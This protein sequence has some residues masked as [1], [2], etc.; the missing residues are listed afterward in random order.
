[1]HVHAHAASRYAFVAT[2]GVEGGSDVRPARVRDLS[3]AGA[4]FAMPKPFSKGT[5]IFVKIR[6]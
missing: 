6:L 3:I 1:M 4:Y 2:A 5:S